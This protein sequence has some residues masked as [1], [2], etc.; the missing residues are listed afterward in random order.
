MREA[1]EKQ[2]VGGEMRSSHSCRLWLS[3]LGRGVLEDSREMAMELGSL[4]G[5][6]KTG[7]IGV[8]SRAIQN[9]E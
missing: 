6:W 9:T 1:S 3:S 4:L 7:E 2:A 8:I 5:L